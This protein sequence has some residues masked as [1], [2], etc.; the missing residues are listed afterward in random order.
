M[1]GNKCCLEEVKDCGL[2]EEDVRSGR[3]E[4]KANGEGE[5]I[6]LELNVGNGTEPGVGERKGLGEVKD[7]G[8][9]GVVAWIGFW[10]DRNGG[11]LEGVNSAGSGDV[12]R[13]GRGEENADDPILGV[14]DGV[15]PCGW[16]V[17]RNKDAGVRGEGVDEGRREL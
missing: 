7:A 14:P 6:E 11:M 13:G 1:L 8:G 3:G 17:V 4:V 15:V 2:E 16:T 10:E 5:E 9:L 12:S